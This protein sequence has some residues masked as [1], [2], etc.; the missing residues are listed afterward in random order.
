M[1]AAT[2][3]FLQAYPYLSFMIVFV[4]IAGAIVRVSRCSA[5]LAWYSGLVA[6]P[7]AVSG[8][9]FVPDYWQP[10]VLLNLGVGIE[11]V[12]FTFAVGVSAWAIVDRGGRLDLACGP[13]RAAAIT[14]RYLLVATPFMT[15]FLSLFWA[16][17]GSMHAALM[18]ANIVGASLLWRKPTLWRTAVDGAIGF[19]ILYCCFLG[20]A[21]VV[22]PKILSYWMAVNRGH[23]T[24]FGLPAGEMA[25]AITWGASWPLVFLF[26]VETPGIEERTPTRVKT[27]AFSVGRASTSSARSVTEA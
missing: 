20:A 6:A 27:L 8:L 24:A 1:L 14:R 22:D 25:W 16:G 3:A 2:V 19:G 7:G 9:V 26:A 13:I 12:L 23:S 10:K 11:D 21:L 17:L 5:T 15:I 18:A 4:M